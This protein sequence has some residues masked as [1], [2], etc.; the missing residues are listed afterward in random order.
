MAYTAE[1][2][3]A[4]ELVKRCGK[5]IEAAFSAEK[6]VTEKS[7]AND[8]V[9]ETDQ[10]VERALI[11]GLRESFPSTRFIGE[12]STAGGEPVQLTEEPTWVIDPIDGTTNFVHSNPQ[13]CTILGFMVKR[14]VQFAIVHAPILGQTWTARKGEGAFC[15]GR[16]IQVSGCT[17]LG[18][19]LLVQEMGATDP[20]K[21][22]MVLANMATFIPKVR[23][24]RAFGSAGLNLAYLAQG[25]VDVYFEYGFHI[26]DYAAPSLLVREAGGVV[27]DPT[28]GGEVDWLARRVLA[29][30]SPALAAAVQPNITGIDLARD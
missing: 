14:E 2:E 24:V 3:F 25:S 1:F 6:R 18:K 20:A 9:T 7:V 23:S 22:K 15:N 17:E 29:A 4:L 10:E 27:M 30:A 5:T 16:R 11:G 12:E 26:W 21:V 13:I 8:L 19:A 28:T